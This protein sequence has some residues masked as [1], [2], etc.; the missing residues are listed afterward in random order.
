MIG[1]RPGDSSGRRTAR[2][3]R[4][5]AAKAGWLHGVPPDAQAVLRSDPELRADKEIV[6]DL[7]Y[8]QYCLQ[9][10]AGQMVSA[11]E[12][13][14]QFPTY[15]QSLLRLLAVHSFLQAHPSALKRPDVQWPAPGDALAEF[16]IVRQ[17]GRGG[18]AHV[19]LARETTAG[20]RA[21]V[22]KVSADGLGEADK[23]GPLSHPHVMRV[24]NARQ[25]GPLAVLTM[26]FLGTATLEDVAAGK[27]TDR[28][29]LE[30]ICATPGAAD[31]P[32]VAETFP[33]PFSASTRF[34]L[35]IAAIGVGVAD[36]LAFLH[37][38]D[39]A[40]QDLKP[41]NVLLTPSG[42]PFLLDFNLTTQAGPS[43]GS[44]GGTVPYMAP[45][46]LAAFCS[47]GT[48]P[49][50]N[51]SAADVY[52][53]GVILYELLADRH[54]FRNEGPTHKLGLPSQEVVA[55]RQQ[56]PTPVTALNP[57]VD[58][59]LAAV[60]M[61]C[62]AAEPT[63]RP[64]AADLAARLRRRLAPPPPRTPRRMPWL[65][66]LGGVT[67]LAIGLGVYF[68][69]TDPAAPT[70]SPIPQT[71]FERGLILLNEDKVAF[72]GK[73]FLD[74][75]QTTQDARAYAFTAYCLAL[76]GS[77]EAAILYS[78]KALEHGSTDVAVLTNRA[79]CNLRLNRLAAA[80]TDCNVALALQPECVEA[81][82]LR[83]QVALAQFLKD[84]KQI[85][86]VQALDDIN[87]VRQNGPPSSEVSQIAA[88]LSVGRGGVADLDE[89]V[90][91]VR[92]AVRRGADPDRFRHNSFLT[93]AIGHR[94]DFKAALE[95]PIDPP[96]Y[97]KAPG[98]LRPKQ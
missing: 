60:V 84:S 79:W 2:W 38:R 74:A 18:F 76:C 19:Y 55:A 91:A 69:L 50:Y 59:V 28:L 54:P 77:S 31:D 40:H 51:R 5:E 23:L 16:T 32:V 92:E 3:T 98:L 41:S 14:E 9:A 33:S 53:L 15:R 21:V 6:L 65:A 61:Q 58:P 7:A 10:A 81:R 70:S 63:H 48:P 71:P 4:A 20:N 39:L 57:T 30:A 85:P 27:P 95:R 83:A 43:H 88:Y 17:L 36:A 93:R 52:S 87:F 46:Q 56:P 94:E 97:L 29:S 90:A 12:F 66:I 64:T 86:G 68:S 45:E 37:A 89:A 49:T 1:N 96:P 47:P 22:L 62:L 44:V 72:A 80:L 11:T 67:V 24:L 25:I 75:A 35:A 13:A 26:P 73:E 78:D 34:D 8:E 82:S 42:F